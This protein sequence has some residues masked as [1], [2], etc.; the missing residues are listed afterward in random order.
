MGDSQCVTRHANSGYPKGVRVNMTQL[1]RE[2]FLL[3]FAL[4]AVHLSGMRVDMTE[5]SCRDAFGMEVMILGFPGSS[6]P[7]SVIRVCIIAA[8][9]GNPNACVPS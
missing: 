3:E 8:L 6:P 7:A 1:T 2:S 5:Y 9:V 4:P